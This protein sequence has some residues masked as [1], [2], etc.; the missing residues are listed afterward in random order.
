MIAT[1]P[2]NPTGGIVAGLGE[3][4]AQACRRRAQIQLAGT[5]INEA[6]GNQ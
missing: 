6:A 2:I 1:T 4:K 5:R 3:E